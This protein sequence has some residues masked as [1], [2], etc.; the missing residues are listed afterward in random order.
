MSIKSLFAAEGVKTRKV[1]VTVDGEEHEAFVG[2]ISADHMA[3]V[4]Q[5]LKDQ[6][7]TGMNCFLVRVGVY[8][9]EAGTRAFTDAPEDQKAIR[10][11]PVQF[12]GALANEVL[13]FNTLSTEDA[14][15]N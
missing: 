11:A 3:R 5:Y 8:D 1:V 9:D 6:D 12:V 13:A 10:N 4:S 14:T 2:K 7:A 15:K